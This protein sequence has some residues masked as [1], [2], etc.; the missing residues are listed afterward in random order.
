LVLIPYYAPHSGYIKEETERAPQEFSIF[1]SQIPVNNTNIIIGTDLNTSIG[2][3][4]T[5]NNF[6]MNEEEDRGFELQEN[7]IPELLGPQGNPHR[8]G[9]GER[10]LNLMREHDLRA[11][12]TKGIQGIEDHTKST[13]QM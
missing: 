1:L 13:L 11:A 3:R 8:N 7:T 4:I 10:I 5:D 12:S 2:T 9:Y 6:P